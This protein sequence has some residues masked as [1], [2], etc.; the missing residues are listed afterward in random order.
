MFEIWK[1]DNYKLWEEYGITE[2]IEIVFREKGWLS[3]QKEL[4]RIHEELYVEDGQ[5]LYPAGL[6]EKY[7]N[8]GKYDKKLDFSEKMYENHNPNLPYISTQ[9]N[10]KLMKDNPRYI[11]LLRKMDLPL[12]DKQ[13]VTKNN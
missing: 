2:H 11:E 13:Q 8:I 10:Y 1:Q 5:L 12:D 3:F 6:A 4:I 9:K 7:F